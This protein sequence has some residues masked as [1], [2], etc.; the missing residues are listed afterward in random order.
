MDVRQLG[1]SGTRTNRAEA[2]ARFY[3]DVLGLRLV[4]TE[5]HF[6]VFELP[7]GN[8][9]KSSDRNT[10]AKNTSTPAPW[11]ASPSLT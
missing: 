10:R 1:W 8:H 6:W 2:L 7:D 4:H 5:P 11:W 3:Q 9:S